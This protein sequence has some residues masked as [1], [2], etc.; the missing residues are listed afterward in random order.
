MLL[1]FPF[2]TAFMWT[3]KGFTIHVHNFIQMI[4]T[5]IHDEATSNQP[6]CMRWY[7]MSHVT[8][9][10]TSH[11]TDL[12]CQFKSLSRLKIEWSLLLHYV[13]SHWKRSMLRIHWQPVDSAHAV[14]KW[15]RYVHAGLHSASYSTPHARIFFRLPDKQYYYNKIVF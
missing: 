1:A 8:W 2:N 5:N 9:T 10:Q 11:F 13:P 12:Y 7:Y 3:A 6:K 4:L 15:G 14:L